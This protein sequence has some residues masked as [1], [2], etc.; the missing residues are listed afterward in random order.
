M[1]GKRRT[2]TQVGCTAQTVARRLCRA[3]YQAAWKAGTLG[4]QVKQPPRRRH[5]TICAPE[6]KHDGSTTCYIQHQCRCEPC[7]TAHN[8]RNTRRE[9][10]KAYGRFDTGLVDADPVREHL[11]M[12]GEFGLGY[13]RVAKL[14]G[15]SITPV[16]NLIWGRQ[17]PGPR[18]GEIPK[19]V[20]RE[21]AL[22][23]LA[24]RPDVAHLADGA[25]VPARSVHRRMQALVHQGWSMSK[26]GVRVGITP[27]NFSAMMGRDRVAAAT[28]RTAVALFDELWNQ[29]PPEGT[30]RDRIA[31]SRARAHAR[32][33]G[34][35]SPLAWDDIDLDDAPAQDGDHE[36]VGIDEQAVELVLAGERLRLNRAERREVVTRLHA[37]RFSDSRIAE[38][39]GLADRTV[40]RIREE[41]GLRA[42][43]M[44]EQAAA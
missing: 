36:G 24:V 5:R 3:H 6:H 7:I 34:W 9:K 10:L 21:N 8:Q 40:L 11:L 16:R 17:D 43:D 18:K 4:Q 13:K 35:V 12:L 20:K 41:L 38:I 15:L 25:L 14:A 30:H 33:H 26:L 22:R 2:C 23:I 28:Y 1:S 42:W 32:H 19:R 37:R 31:A 44:H 27:A 39:S 29:A